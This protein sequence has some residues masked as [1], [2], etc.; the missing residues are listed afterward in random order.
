MTKYKEY[1]RNKGIKMECDFDYLP[2]NGLE[3]VTTGIKY[4]TVYAKAYFNTVGFSTICIN[5]Y[6]ERVECP[7]VP[8]RYYAFKYWINWRCIDEEVIDR[9]LELYQT[10]D[11]HIMYDRYCAK[12]VSWRQMYAYTEKLYNRTYTDKHIVIE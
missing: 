1:L 7:T 10:T 11:L 3:S 6:G 4:D 2:Y 9:M 8:E 5:R 12:Q